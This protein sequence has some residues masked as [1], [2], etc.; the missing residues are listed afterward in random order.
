M[1]L[2][3]VLHGLMFMELNRTSGFLEISA[4]LMKQHAHRFKGGTRGNLVDLIGPIDWTGGK[5]TG[6]QG[7][8]DPTK[9]VSPG[10]LQFSKHPLE[11]EVGAFNPKDAKRLIKLPWP[12]SFSA[13]RA[14]D[15]N[16][17]TPQPGVIG[18]NILKW[19]KRTNATTGKPN[20]M[21]GLITVL[22]YTYDFPDLPIPGLTHSWTLHF[23]HNGN[24]HGPIAEVNDDLQDAADAFTNPAGF[25]VRLKPD[26]NY[27]RVPLDPA[28]ILPKGMT[29]EDELSLDEPITALDGVVEEFFIRVVKMKRPDQKDFQPFVTG[30]AD[31]L[32][33]ANCPIF[34]VQDQPFP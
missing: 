18:Q 3:I 26:G 4:P 14:A 19:C 6:K 28:N 31:M 22:N 34:Y 8:P 24:L 32:N 30:L 1:N 27:P 17:F 13:Y 23:F 9:D 15:I 11:T 29:P 25:D 21:V 7:D 16:S 12:I 2:N 20:T 33:P 5:L 10:I